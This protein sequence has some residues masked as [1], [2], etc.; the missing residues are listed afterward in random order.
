MY[1]TY[2]LNEIPVITKYYTVVRNTFW[3]ITDRDNILIFVTDG[4]CIIDYEG[5]SYNLKRGD[6]FFV[7][8]NHSYTRKPVGSEK[9]TC[10]YIHFSLES[11][12][13]CRK[14]EKLTDDI[15]ETREALNIEFLSGEPSP[16]YP[17]TIYIENKTSFSDFSQVKQ[18]LSEINLFSNN[19]QLMCS[20]Q[21]SVMLCG[22]LTLLSQKT[23]DSLSANTQLR[24][25]AD[26]PPNLRKT[27][28]YIA[29]NY[30]KHITLED[31]ARNCNVSK[32]QLIRYFK[33][34]FNTT[35]INYITEYKL[36]RAK[37]LLFYHPQLTVKEIA[38]ELGFE[39]QHYFSRV[40][41][42][43][44]NESPISYRNRVINYKE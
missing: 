33:N 15:R 27:I 6:V 35:P 18:F 28:N 3:Q 40:F 31:L 8:E 24:G 4:R 30:S 34:A 29:R 36:S 37:E 38:S 11:C 32:Q 9:V 23:V 19:R 22:I 1:Y 5:E 7:P 21:S 25:A 43:H 42:K 10:I 14:M 2:E 41:S 16:H 26:I 17:R 20:M 12:F 39:N 44:N 13:E